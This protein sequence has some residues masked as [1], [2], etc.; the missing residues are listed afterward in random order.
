MSDKVIEH[1]S[2]LTRNQDG[3]FSV[4]FR[5][6]FYYSTYKHVRMLTSC[7]VTN[8]KILLCLIPVS[9]EVYHYTE[10]IRENYHLLVYLAN[11]VLG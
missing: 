4:S 3:S 8:I 2:R 1:R 5:Y 6:R 10:T 7:L 9:S 11:T